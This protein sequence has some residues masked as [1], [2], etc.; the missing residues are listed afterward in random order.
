MHTSFYIG[1][2]KVGST[3]L[4]VFLSQN[5][6]RLARAGILYPF[7]EMTGAAEA[8]ARGLRGDRAQILPVNIREAHSALA[9]KMMSE[10]SDFTVPKQFRN[11]PHSRQMIH[12]IRAQIAALQP[13]G[14]ILCSEVFSNFGSVNP[15][16]IDSVAGLIGD[17]TASLYC[18]L[19]RPDQYLVS[20]H[21]QRIK[22]GRK[23]KRLSEGGWQGYRRTIHFDYRLALEPWLDA[24]RGHRITIRNYA[25][26]IAAGGSEADYMAHSGLEFPDGMIPAPAANKS[27]PLAAL[28]IARRGNEVL[29]GPGQ[30]QLVSLLQGLADHPQMPRN[31]DVE[32]FGA[33]ARKRIHDGFR[34]IHDW[35][36][37]IAGTAAFFPDFDDLLSTRPIPEDQATRAV[38]DLIQPSMTE[39]LP[40]PVREFL[41][42]ERAR[43]AQTTG[44]QAGVRT[45]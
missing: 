12:G 38:L 40:R 25:D 9:Y 2:H 26:I 24:F 29:A 43:F 10:A 28:D 21:G 13:R 5:F 20:W 1:Q 7:T 16:L 4:Q 34:P 27:I 14:M 41:Q 17:G 30:K 37:Q 33:A 39:P 11:L 32:M 45:S 23:V 19:R 15:A 36:S 22:V 42:Q 35:L 31:G 6:D 8:M 44:P 3:S 18:A